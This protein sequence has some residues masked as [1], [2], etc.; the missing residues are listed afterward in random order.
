[1]EIAQYILMIVSVSH[2]S[3]LA[4]LFEKLKTRSL[5]EG[6]KIKNGVFYRKQSSNGNFVHKSNFE[7]YSIDIFSLNM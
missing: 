4:M 3:T 5:I 6:Y 1:M 7:K 2:F